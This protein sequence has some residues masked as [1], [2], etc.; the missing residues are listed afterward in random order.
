MSAELGRWMSRDGTCSLLEPVSLRWRWILFG[1]A[2]VRDLGGGIVS[3]VLQGGYDRGA[4]TSLSN[5]HCIMRLQ[6]RKK[7]T[8]DAECWRGDSV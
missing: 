4:A 6:M 3:A 5:E 2:S 7:H 1:F 8:G